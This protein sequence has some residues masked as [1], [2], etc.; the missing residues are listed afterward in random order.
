MKSDGQISISAMWKEG[1]PKSDMQQ[2]L[3]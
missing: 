1:W 3:W 2:Y